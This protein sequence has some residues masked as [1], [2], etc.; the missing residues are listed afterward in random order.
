MGGKDVAAGEAILNRANIPTFPY[1][2]TAARMFDYMVRYADNLHTLYE[3]P[4]SA[5]ERRQEA[6][7]DRA[8]AAQIIQ[9][10]RESGRTILTEYESKQLLAAYGIPI[11]ET[12][13]APVG[14][15]SG[16]GRGG[17]GL[18]RRAQAALGDDHAQDG[19]GRRAVEP[20]RRRGGAPARS[21]RSR[22]R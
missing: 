9:T 5:D 14:R 4:V 16:R 10:V 3:T 12:R 11:G 17:D 6:D 21:M 18:S 19:C 20:G 1:P 2:D 22:P 8:K 13:I 15:R 7:I